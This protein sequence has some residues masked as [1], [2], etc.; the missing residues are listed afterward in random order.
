MQVW[1]ISRRRI[2]RLSFILTSL[3]VAYL[4]IVWQATGNLAAPTTA[5]FVHATA[6]LLLGNREQQSRRVRQQA[7]SGQAARKDEQET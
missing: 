3:D 5:A 7:C 2:A 6:E 1:L 4:G